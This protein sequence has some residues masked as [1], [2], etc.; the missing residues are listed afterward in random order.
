MGYQASIGD[1]TSFLLSA[2][3]QI[4]EDIHFIGCSSLQPTSYNQRPCVVYPHIYVS[5][6]PRLT[7]P[8]LQE[9]QHSSTPS[10]PSSP[11]HP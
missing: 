1:T 9:P 11:S 6:I 2:S 5:P 3:T 4:R 7:M 8:S 10:S